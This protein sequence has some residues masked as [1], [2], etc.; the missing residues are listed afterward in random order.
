MNKLFT[1]DFKKILLDEIPSF[2]EYGHKFINGEVSKMDFKKVSGGFGIYAQRDQKSF[3]IRLRVS[4]G[5]FSREQLHK[6]YEVAKKYNL[7][8]VHLTTR[9]AVQLHDLSIDNVCDIMEECIHKDVF[10]RGGGGNF[11]R[12]V[13]ISP[14]SGV[15]IDDKFDIVPYALACD[16]HFIKNS[17]T[18]NLPRK[19]KVSLASNDKD[20]SHCTVQD[21]GFIA[22]KNGTDECFKVYFGGGLG[23]N[24][25]IAIEYG[26]IIKA[27][28]I[29]YHID[30][31]VLMFIKN[32]NYENKNKARVRYMID[33]LGEDGFRTEYKKALDEV[34]SKGELDLTILPIDYE[35]NGFE[36]DIKHPRLFNQKQKGLYS[37]YVHPTGGQFYLKN[38]KNLLDE[39]D[40][41]ENIYVRS[42]MSEGFYILNLNGNEAKKVLELTS[43]YS[44]E[45][46]LE[47]SVA[48]IG[49]PICQMGILRSQHLLEDIIQ[50]FKS[51]NYTKDI[52]PA[53]HI[54]GCSNSCS[55][56]QISDIGFIGKMKRVN[57]VSS[58]V[59]Q[60]NIGGSF[61]V[62]NAK[63]GKVCGDIKE[64]EVKVFLYELSEEVDKSNL[65]FNEFITNHEDIL[66][67]LISKYTV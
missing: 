67:E 39:L 40:E 19:L 51:K 59:Y 43:S 53:V 25:K 3:M 63:L 42:Y 50:Y 15:D 18:Y 35:K 13:A 10:T 66:N 27:K 44:G 30:A 2:R 47:Q 34:K 17:Y 26:E 6:V 54:T 8:K 38:Y 5:V 57:D 4:C 61:G 65:S 62:G 16:N 56:P 46:K 64:D 36:I 7:E 33:T 1:E 9:Q 48:C 29:L 41:M 14:L 11:P 12:N 22:V 37:V 24:P 55:V 20:E 58:P 21:L 32:G 23:R 45:T 60:L 31:M 49:V 28:D 52:L